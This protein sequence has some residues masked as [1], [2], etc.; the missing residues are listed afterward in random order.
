MVTDEM[1]LED[2]AL[3][4]QEGAE[5]A[6][7]KQVEGEPDEVKVALTELAKSQKGIVEELGR[8]RESRREEEPELTAEQ[9]A[10]FWAIYDP[11]K[12]DKEFFKKFFRMNPEATE[13]EVKAA[14]QMFRDVQQGFVRQSVKGAKNYVDYM[15][16]Q[17]RDEMRPIYEFAETQRATATRGRF[18]ESYESLKDKKYE[19]IIAGVARTLADRTFDDEPHYFKTLAEGVADA[20]KSVVPDFDLGQKKQP[21]GKHTKVPRSS[22]GGSGG[23]GRGGSH[24]VLQSQDAAAE[25]FEGD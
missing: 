6:G 15:V 19:K 16:R 25:I 7:E 9:K 8:Q 23:A 14:A 3:L 10:E 21:A 24:E 1:E 22:V 18:F 17:L 4:G 13:D 2:D 11:E 12:S 5:G 20:I